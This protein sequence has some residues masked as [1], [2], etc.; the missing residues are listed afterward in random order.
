MPRP[1]ELLVA[2]GLLAPEQVEQALRAQVL[3]GG[4]LGTNLVE[5]HY[6]E[7]DP[8]SRVLGRQHHLPA[9]LARHFEKADPELQA[10]L[11]S[12]IAER[13][14]CLP[15]LPMGPDQHV[16]IASVT[17]LTPRQLAIIAS[18]LAVDVARL[19]PAV[20]AELRIRYQLERVYR[21]RRAQRYLRARGASIPPFPAFQIL[22]VQPD[23]ELDFST[24]SLPVS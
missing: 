19:V 2:A 4:R 24:P 3:W 13:F 12:R 5:L 21:I 14:S 1:G 10:R 16:V 6:L 18:E 8:L 23:A 22:P 15:L 20:A 17:P 11:P 7:L 9:A